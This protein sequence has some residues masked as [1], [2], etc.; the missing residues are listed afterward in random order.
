MTLRCDLDAEQTARYDAAAELWQ[1]GRAAPRSRAAGACARCYNSCCAPW[2][3]RADAPPPVGCG[4]NSSGIGIANAAGGIGCNRNGV[5]A[6]WAR[7]WRLHAVPAARAVQCWNR[8]GRCM[9]TRRA[10]AG[11]SRAAAGGGRADRHH[12]ARRMEAVL[13]RAAAL[14]Q[15]ALHQHEGAPRRRRP[16]P[17]HTYLVAAGFMQQCSTLVAPVAISL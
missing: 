8:Q 15:A 17:G 11:P 13:G 3:A 14:L 12:L 9:Q 6:C 4:L 1:V 7:A 10:G 16:P 5:M 2:A